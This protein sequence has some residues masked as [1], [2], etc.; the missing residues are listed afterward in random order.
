MCFLL[1]NVSFLLV[2]RIV[3]ALRGRIACRRRG[4]V[5][6]KPSW[7]RPDDTV[8]R[9]QTVV[10]SDVN[11]FNSTACTRRKTWTCCSTRVEGAWPSATGSAQVLREQIEV[12]RHPYSGPCSERYSVACLCWCC[13]ELIIASNAHKVCC[14]FLTRWTTNKSPF[15]PTGWIGIG[16]HIERKLVNSCTVLACS[17][18]SR[19]RA[20]LSGWNLRSRFTRTRPS[21]W[22]KVLTQNQNTFQLAVMQQT[23]MAK[24]ASVGPGPTWRAPA[25]CVLYTIAGRPRIPTMRPACRYTWSIQTHTHTHTNHST[26]CILAIHPAKIV[27]LVRLWRWWAPQI[28]W[29]GTQ[30]VCQG[31]ISHSI[32]QRGQGHCVRVWLA[33]HF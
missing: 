15:H 2:R 6:S 12:Y 23:Q 9:T 25:I 5:W 21:K 27:A 19:A 7:H 29:W 33:R 11:A 16:T 22:T 32:W 30:S 10:S 13:C 8:V 28:P 14:N 17:F 18:I 1:V 24:F 4:R 31:W 26:P 3:Q 20:H